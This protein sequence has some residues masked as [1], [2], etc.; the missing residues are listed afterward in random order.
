MGGWVMSWYDYVVEE[1]EEKA[2]AL[3]TR[4]GT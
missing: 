1:E 2:C 3:L 4:S